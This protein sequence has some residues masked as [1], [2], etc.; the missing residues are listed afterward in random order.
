M[1]LSFNIDLIY[2]HFEAIIVQYSLTPIPDP[3]P[4]RP[5]AFHDKTMPF[6][7]NHLKPIQEALNSL[8]QYCKETDM[9]RQK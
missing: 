8:V 3:N 4:P 7:P 5:L 1:K 2:M 9:I 6:L